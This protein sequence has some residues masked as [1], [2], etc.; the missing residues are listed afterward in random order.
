MK[1]HHQKQLI[2]MLAA[3]ALCAPLAA[4]AASSGVAELTPEHF[5]QL[6]RNKDGGI[7]RDEYEQFMRDAF[8]DLD[9][10]GDGRLSPQEAAAI[11]SPEQFKS[12]DT[13]NSNDITL[14]ELIAHVMRDFDA[15]DYN[16]DGK[17][18]R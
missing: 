3:L 2:G 17:L 9:K 16:R 6:D 12:V 11:L 8:R 14:D 15:H 1:Q 13:D 7:S 4:Q 10:N 5:A 18:Q